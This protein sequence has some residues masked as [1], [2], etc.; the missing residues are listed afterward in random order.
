MSSITLR[1]WPPAPRPTPPPPQPGHDCLWRLDLLSRNDVKF[2]KRCEYKRCFENGY[3]TI[4]NPGTALECGL[5]ALIDSLYAQI[6]VEEESDI[7]PDLDVLRWTWAEYKAERAAWIEASAAPEEREFELERISNNE[8]F[9][10]DQL[11]IILN[12][13]GRRHLNLDLALGLI[14][15]GEEPNI[16]DVMPDAAHAEAKTDLKRELPVRVVWIANDNMELLTGGEAMSH[17]EGLRP[18]SK[19]EAAR[20]VA[21]QRGDA[22]AA[23]RKA[24]RRRR[25]KSEFR[26]LG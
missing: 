13:Y 2:A 14:I 23:A 15:P 10:A 11:A 6:I 3:K 5:Y 1:S 22:A 7:L 20:D 12:R 4:E 18:M 17:Y 24:W 21:K 8:H 26:G 9:G 25:R 16:F 19:I